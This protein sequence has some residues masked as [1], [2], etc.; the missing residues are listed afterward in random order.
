MSKMFFLAFSAVLVLGTP[1]SARVHKKACQ[2]QLELT[3]A[4]SISNCH[5]TGRPATAKAMVRLSLT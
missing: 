3:G 2:I 1:A 4:V 5:F